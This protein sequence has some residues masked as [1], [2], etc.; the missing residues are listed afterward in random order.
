MSSSTQETRNHSF[1]QCLRRLEQIVEQLE[2]GSVSLEESIAM[3]E[4][5]ILLS[6][7]CM[8]KLNKAELKLKTLG[9]DMRGNF[10]LFDEEPDQ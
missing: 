5:G 10:R 4:E 7:E 8:D 6:K 9:K 1:E 3:Y 2:Q